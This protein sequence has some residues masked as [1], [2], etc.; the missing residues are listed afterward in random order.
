[1]AGTRQPTALLEAKGKKHLTKAEIEERKSKEIKAPADKVTPPKYL[2][3]EQKKTFN[4]IKKQLL[5]IELI[6]NLD[7]D[8]L[9]RFIIAQEKYIEVTQKIA[10]TPLTVELKKEIKDKDDKTIGIE[11]VEIVNPLVDKL[12]IIQDRL[13]K[14]CRQGA[15][16]FGLTITSRCRLVV[17]KPK[18][19][20][21]N[22]FDKFLNKKGKA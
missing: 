2:T 5:A 16:D 22:K 3:K 10:E 8:A 18:E 7:V 12:L 11:N 15:D 1:M 21:H 13:F 20:K 14:Q 6:S 17:P 19:E 4:K 9:A